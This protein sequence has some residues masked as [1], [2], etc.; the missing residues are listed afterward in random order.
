MTA[1]GTWPI[2]LGR[3][4]GGRIILLETHFPGVPPRWDLGVLSTWCH[5]NL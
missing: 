1:M 5:E 3:G 2:V 4:A